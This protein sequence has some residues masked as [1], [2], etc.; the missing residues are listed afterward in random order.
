MAFGQVVRLPPVRS[1][2]AENQLF[3]ATSPLHL[4]IVDDDFVRIAADRYPELRLLDV[5]RL[6][7]AIV[8]FLLCQ[9]VLDVLGEESEER[10][11]LERCDAKGAGDLA[12]GVV[13]DV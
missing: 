3:E 4:L 9:V 6:F 5:L 1:E 12:D 11:R 2:L 10:L 8:P 7:S 13:V